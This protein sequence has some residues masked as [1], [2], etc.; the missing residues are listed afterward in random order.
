MIRPCRSRIFPLAFSLLRK[1][2]NPF[3][4]LHCMS[5]LL[6][7]SEKTSFFSFGSH[8]GPS[9]NFMPPASFMTFAPGA[10]SELRSS[11]ASAGVVIS[12][13]KDVNKI[14]FAGDIASSDCGFI[15]GVVILS[16]LLENKRRVFPVY[17]GRTILAPRF[18]SS[19][20]VRRSSGGMLT[21]FQLSHFT[22]TQAPGE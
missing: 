2:D 1:T 10:T 15:E 18:C 13:R 8:T 9:V 3:F 22:R 17:H 20:E 21:N 4:A 11:A 14:E 5:L 6:G 19:R 12:N 7:M 16:K